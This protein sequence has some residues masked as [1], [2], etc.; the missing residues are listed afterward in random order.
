MTIEQ[1]VRHCREHPEL[2]DD[3][4]CDQR[5]V[6]YGLTNFLVAEGRGLHFLIPAAYHVQ[7]TCPPHER[8]K[9]RFATDG[10]DSVDA[11]ERSLR[12]RD[13]DDWER[14]ELMYPGCHWDVF[15]DAFSSLVDSAE[16]LA[17]K[18][19][20]GH[21]VWLAEQARRGVTVVNTESSGSQLLIPPGFQST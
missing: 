13:K 5:V 7:L 9:R 20:A 10:G 4:R 21:Q 18:I 8:A 15:D 12:Q 11:V 17:D 16:T 1:F 2:G 14:Y 3:H 6:E 19:L